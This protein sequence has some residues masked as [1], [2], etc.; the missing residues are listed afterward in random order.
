VLPTVDTVAI[1]DEKHLATTI[2]PQPRARAA[3]IGP[4]NGALAAATFVGHSWQDAPDDHSRKAP[5]E[6]ASFLKRPAT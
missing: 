3:D 4:A 5:G 1:C 2:G 6:N